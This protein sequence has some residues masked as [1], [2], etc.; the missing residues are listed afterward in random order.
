MAVAY[1]PYNPDQARFLSALSM[2]EIGRAKNGVNLGNGFVDLTRAPRNQYGFPIWQGQPTADGR[3]SR[4]AG[5]FQFQPGTWEGYARD[6][7]LDFQDAADQKRGAWYLAQ[8]TYKSETGGDLLSALQAKEYGA[9]E[10]ALGRT[11]WIG[12][13]GKLAAFLSAGKGATL[14]GGPGGPSDDTTDFAEAMRRN[15]EEGGEIGRFFSSKG[16]AITDTIQRYLIFIVGGLILAAALWW[17]L[18]DAN[19]IPTP[20]GLIKGAAG[21]V[22]KGAT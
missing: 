21:A 11:Q 6:Y 13:R 2:S 10:S 22:V 5:L 12:A 16:Q 15:R 19:L 7:D 8:D 3:G 14:P 4:A 20:G 1:D 17:L 18:S 9:I